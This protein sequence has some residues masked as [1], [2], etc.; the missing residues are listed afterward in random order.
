MSEPPAIVDCVD[1]KVYRR[2]VKVRHSLE[3]INDWH[4]GLIEGEVCVDLRITS[5]VRRCLVPWGRLCIPGENGVA[6]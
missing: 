5:K 6:P 3:G 2:M 4:G 1:R